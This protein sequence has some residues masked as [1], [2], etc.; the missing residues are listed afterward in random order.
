MVRIMI[1]AYLAINILFYLIINAVDINGYFLK[2]K[3]STS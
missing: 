1:I 2:Y 3:N